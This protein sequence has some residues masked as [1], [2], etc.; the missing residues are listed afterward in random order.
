[1]TDQQRIESG[2]L[3]WIIFLRDKLITLEDWFFTQRRI[4]LYGF[5]AI[6]AYAIGLVA[7]WFQHSWLFFADG[8]QSCNDF[9]YHLVSGA[10]AGSGNRGLVYDFST[11]SAPRAALG[12]G[13]ACV[14]PVLNQFVYP[15]TILFF[16]YPL[17]LIPYITRLAVWMSATLL[18]YLAP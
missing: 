4:W 8:K 15:P 18:L 6:A 12:G 14:A 16:T 2:S 13:D 11:F 3:D 1:M 7:R 17:G 5:G 10:L 9:A